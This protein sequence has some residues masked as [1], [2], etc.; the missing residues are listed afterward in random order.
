MVLGQYT[1]SPEATYETIW[2]IFFLA[3]QTMYCIDTINSFSL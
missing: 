3:S 2:T 1:S